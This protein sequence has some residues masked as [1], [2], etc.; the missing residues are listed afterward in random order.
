MRRAYRL[1][2][3]ESP[4]A[5]MRR[6]ALGRAEQAGERLRAA[7]RDADPAARVHGARK[8]L[9]KLRAIVKLVRPELGE[10]RYRAENERYRDA[11]RLLSASRDAEV[12]RLTLEALRERFP[13]ALE[14]GDE[15]WLDALR[16]ERDLAVETAR[17]GAAT[18]LGQAIAM[19]KRGSAQIAAWPLETDSWK[20]VGPGIERTYRRGRRAMRRSKEDPEPATMHEWRKRA[21]DLWYQLRVLQPAVPGRF[22]EKLDQAKQLAEALGDHHDLA[23]LRDDLVVR[24]LPTVDRPAVVAAIAARQDELTAIALD[25]GE[26]LYAEKP[27]VF[28]KEMRRGWEEWRSG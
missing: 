5:G 21:K 12:K 24:D 22:S 6:V 17:E 13:H 14:P 7:E 25:L 3:G 26:R 19:V 1:E 9:K 2:K 28:R 18:S 4:S 20:L 15:E 23:L 10:D 11:G 8:D 16:E 27:K